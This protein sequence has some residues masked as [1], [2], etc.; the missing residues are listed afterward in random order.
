MRRKTF[1]ANPM[2][3][4]EA[5][6]DVE[7]L[8]HDFYLFT[9]LHTGADSCVRTTPEGVELRQIDG[10]PDYARGVAAVAVALGPPPPALTEAE[11]IERLDLGGERF[12]FFQDADTGRGAVV[13]HRYDG[14]YGVVTLG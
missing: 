1:D 5:A 7:L 8:G 11:A 3:V 10:G 2:T 13:Y 4:D 12:V 9:E 6:Y 14:H